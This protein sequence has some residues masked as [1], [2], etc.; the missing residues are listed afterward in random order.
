MARI[1]TELVKIS[2]ER[3]VELTALKQILEDRNEELGVFS[4]LGQTDYTFVLIGWIPKKFFKNTQNELRDNFG[5]RVLV[6]EI[7]I[8]PEEM[9]N[10]PTFYDNPRI[11]KPFE[12]LMK[13]V[14]PAKSTEFDRAR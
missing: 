6:N 13:V 3:S 14:S 12:Y 2:T 11:V 9:A 7:P 1:N 10:A 5:G 8:T 4:R